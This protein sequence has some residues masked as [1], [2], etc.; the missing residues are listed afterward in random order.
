V[1]KP[2]GK[3]LLEGDCLIMLNVAEI[4]GMRPEM[5]NVLDK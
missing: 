5:V 2:K 3:E 4:G 1:T